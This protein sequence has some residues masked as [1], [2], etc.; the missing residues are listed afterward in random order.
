MGALAG[1]TA[2]NC[3]KDC[4]GGESDACKACTTE[5]CVPA[6]MTCSGL[7]PPAAAAV[8]VEVTASVGDSTC[9]NAADQSIW[10]AKGQAA[11]D[12]DMNKCGK[13]CL[14]KADCVTACIEEAEGYSAVGVRA[15]CGCLPVGV[16]LVLDC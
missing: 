7:S 10:T 3:W 4:I 13:Q 5:Q 11:F 12:A 15:C 16:M 2:A 1:C 6:F 14:G 8:A 9:M